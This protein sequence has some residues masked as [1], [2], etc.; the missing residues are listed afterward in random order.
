MKETT[1]LFQ[2][3]ELCKNGKV[4]IINLLDIGNVDIMDFWE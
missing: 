2:R 1:K 4:H 3:Q